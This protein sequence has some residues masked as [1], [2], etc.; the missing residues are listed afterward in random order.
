MRRW[1]AAGRV[2]ADGTRPVV[3]GIVN[4]TPDSFS[5]GGRRPTVVEAVARGLALAGEGAAILDVGGESSRPGAEPV[6]AAEE[7]ARVVPVVEALA[8][9]GGVPV[10]VDTTKAEVAAEALRAGAAIVNDITAMADP[11]LARV[12]AGSGAGVVLMH[13]RGTPRTMQV[14]PS[15]ED[16]VTEIYDFLARRVEAAEALGIG[17]ER[18]AIDPGIGFG[19]T[20]RHNLELLRNLGRFA[21]LGCAVL[22]GTSRKGFL[23]ALTGRPVGDRVAASV[24]SAL[25]AVARGAD[26]VR[27][28]DV[29]ATV[30]AFKVWAPL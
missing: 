14:E 27:V 15:Y 6:P 28:H 5:G 11:D 4:V 23:G 2:F 24:A 25:A 8:A 12:V 21:N 20:S 7:I 19:K 18:V 26:V 1:A 22:V 13:M 10:S 3:M 30:D 16:V 9:S 17:R 29:A